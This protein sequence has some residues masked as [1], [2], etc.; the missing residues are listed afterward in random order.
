MIPDA[1]TCIAIVRLCGTAVFCIASLILCLG[2][3]WV[4]VLLIKLVLDAI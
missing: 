4:C 2:G 1:E 3:L